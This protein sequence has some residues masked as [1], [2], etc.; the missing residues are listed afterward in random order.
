MTYNTRNLSHDSIEN[1]KEK[2][3]CFNTHTGEE[4]ET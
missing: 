2:K 3:T 4:S 1:Q